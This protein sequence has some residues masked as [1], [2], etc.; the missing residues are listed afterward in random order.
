MREVHDK[1]LLATAERAE[2]RYVPV[3]AHQ[4]KQA[5]EEASRRPQCQA[6][7]NL[8][9]QAG[10]DC[11]IAV[12]GL[13]PTLARRL[14]RPSDI[15]VQ[16]DRRGS[17]ALE[18]LVIRWPVLHLVAQ[19]VRSAHLP[20]LSCWIHEIDP[21]RDLCNGAGSQQLRRKSCLLSPIWSSCLTAG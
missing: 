8:H 10:H 3:Q 7:Q 18:H 11:R 2:V 13:S 14:C 1:G 20:K 16:Q 6:E 21:L 4:A 15:S 12:D 9:R 5:L 19:G 17:Q